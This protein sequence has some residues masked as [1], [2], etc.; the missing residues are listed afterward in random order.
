MCQISLFGPS[1]VLDS[2]HVPQF[3]NDYPEFDSFRG[4][5]DVQNPEPEN[6]LNKLCLILTDK[7]KNILLFSQ[8]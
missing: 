6:P 5:Y 3:R 2:V 7:S 4:S 1:V 8:N